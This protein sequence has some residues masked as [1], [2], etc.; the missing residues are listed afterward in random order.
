M[1]FAA[2]VNVP[3]PKSSFVDN[4]ANNSIKLEELTYPVVLKPSKSWIKLD[5]KWLRRT[6][7]YADDLVSARKILDTDPAFQSHPFMIQERVEGQGKGIFAL[8]NQG[9]AV[10]F[11]AHRRL[12]EKPPSGWCQRSF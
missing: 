8:Y 11:F 5:Q 9:K 6:V 1:R 4:P 3:V 10:A 12:R 2:S 7:R